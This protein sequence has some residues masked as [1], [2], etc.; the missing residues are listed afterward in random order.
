MKR[1]VFIIAV[2]AILI[3]WRVIR[4]PSPT[5]A[6]VNLA[7]ETVS[8]TDDADRMS[9]G[10]LIAMA[11]TSVEH[12]RNSLVDYTADFVK[13]ERD[14]DGVLG[15]P[16]R[17]AVRIKTGLAD[18]DN[19]S[20]KRVYL[21]FAEPKNLD[22]REVIWGEDLYEG[23]M[24][25]HEVGFLLGLKTIWLNPTGLIAMQGQRYPV[26]EIGLVRLAEKL[27]E[28]GEAMVD[29]EGIMV[30][31]TNDVEFDGNIATKFRI[32][33]TTPSGEEDDFSV[34]EVIID[35]DR[36]LVLS[37]ESYDWPQEGTEGQGETTGRPLLESYQ[38][39][40]VKT[41]VGLSDQDFDVKNPEYEFPAF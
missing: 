28:R 36:H 32:E 19:G 29:E 22:G 37:Y 5:T 26:S 34:A 30:T 9:I 6:D 24:A 39:R 12:M 38:Y 7:N 15:E 33:R 11:R 2:L 17:L 21:R 4:N 23:Q 40:N 35:F 31:Q 10:D 25:V 18:P 16:G 8:L 13:Q 1:I 14:E 20:G 3:G 41:N 27:I